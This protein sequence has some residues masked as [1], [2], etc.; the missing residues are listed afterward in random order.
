MSGARRV[1]PEVGVE[2][3]RHREQRAGVRDVHRFIATVSNAIP[4][5]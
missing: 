2:L 3:V 1:A 5:I 4:G